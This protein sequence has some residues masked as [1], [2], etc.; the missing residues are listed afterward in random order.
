MAFSFDVAS[1]IPR[2]N[3]SGTDTG[4]SGIATAINAVVSVAR[5]TAYTTA[6]LRKPPTPTG[7]WYRCS[8]AGTTAATAPT[9]GTTDG[10][11]TTD[12]TSVWTAFKAPDI[13]TLGTTNHYYM[14]A[15]RMAINGTLTNSNPQ[16]ENFTCYDIIIYTGNFTS[17][18]W[19]TDGVTPRWDGLHFAAVRTSGSG[20]DGVAMALQNSGQFTF[21]G[22]E[23]QCA[24]GVTFDNGTTPRSYY[25]R[26][27]NT[28]EYGA[29]SARFRSYTTN[30]IFQNVETYDF[31]FD[32][33]RMPTVAPSIKARGSEYVYQYVG[34]LAGG[35]DAKFSASSLEN[36]DGTYDFDNYSGGWVELYNCAKGENLNVVSQYPGSSIWVR[37]CVPLYQDIRI[38]AKD[39]TGSVLQNVRFNCTD[40]PTNSPTV[41]FTTVSA[42]KTWD[43]RNPLS[44][45]TTTNASGIALSTPVLNVWY[46]QTTFK[47]NL[48]FPLSTATYQGRAYNYKTMNVSVVLGSNSIQDVS[49]GMI[50]LDTATTV[51]ESVASAITGISL[52]PSGATGG[53]ITISSNKTLQDVWNYYRYWISQFANKTSNDTWTCTGGILDSKLWTL[54]VN[55]GVTLSG[56]SEITQYKTSG[57]ITN[58]GS[59]TAIYG[60]STGTSTVLTISGFD[61]GSSVYVEDNLFVQKHYTA[62]ATGSVVV[63]IPPTASGSWYYAVEKYGNQRQSDF[64]T[65]SGGQ[66]SIVVKALQDVAITQTT[67]ATVG[68]YTA[69]ETPDKIYDYVAFL[70]LSVPHISYGQIVSK[71]GTALNLVDADL[72]VNQSFGSVAEFDYDAKLLTIKSTSLGTGVTFNL[73]KTTPPATIEAN[74]NE[75][76]SVNIEDANGDSSVTIQGGSGNFT[77]WKITNATAEDDYAT[78]TNLGNVGNVTYRFLSNSTHKIVIRDNTTGFRQ[79]VTMAKGNYIKGLFFGDQV[80]LAQSAEVTEINNK[81]D[82]IKV[83]L[84]SNLDVKVSTRLADA[85]YIDPATAQD[86]WEYTT[87]TLTSAGASGATLEEIEGSLILAKEATS[88]DIK[89]QTDKMQFNAQ[90]HIAANVHQLQPGAITDIQNGLSLETTSQGIKAKVDTLTNYDDS[91][92]QTKLDAIQTSVNDIDI[93]GVTDDLTIINENV[94]DASL[95]IPATRNL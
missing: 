13:Q 94:K 60:D 4:L 78:G 84:D 6:M 73:I 12:G 61:A 51:T 83:N 87:R 43:F 90:N 21:I 74:T 49:A 41:T 36:V 92:T 9:Y 70:R 32:L 48:R 5:S 23:V 76:I 50:S 29:S 80:Q 14:P 34:S 81:V 8:T 95:F 85:D 79:V 19:A 18:A 27:R 82:V 63:Y 24:N 88:Q 31:A 35:A 86:V 77:L 33:F 53:V 89:T 72:L 58:N 69:L 15:V 10:G 28:R 66:K 56:T 25:T 2:L 11:T 1:N 47:E 22:G 44:Y 93:A 30:A 67:Q 54:V 91:T 7:F 26:W 45:E 42:L 3:Q 20:A 68:A 16:Q 40:S 71:D 55:S 62:S 39:T 37:H 46:W 59:I 38:T 52:V 65:F 64:F 17:G 57:I 75:V